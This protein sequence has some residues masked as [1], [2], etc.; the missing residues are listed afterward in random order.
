MDPKRIVASGYDRLAGRY[1]RWASELR[2]EERE[3]YTTLLMEGLPAG[4]AVLDLGCGSGML[5]TRRLAIRFAVTGV[6]LSARLIEQAR[7][8]VPSATFICGDMTRLSFP[9]ARFDGVA[10]FYSL[11]H[12]P[13]DDLAPLLACVA[14]WLRP[15]GLFVAS[16]GASRDPGSIEHD[17]LGVPMY[18]S[19][20]DSA[21]GRQLVAQAGLQIVSART[22]I[23]EEDDRPVPFL[24]VVARKPAPDA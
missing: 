6:D 3:R 5:L 11:T 22:E 13:P 19:G 16:M 14:T 15:G 2:V 20:H 23:A 9:P 24:W 12:V 21:T 10:A 1:D 18:F 17:W 8:N 7:R 4:A